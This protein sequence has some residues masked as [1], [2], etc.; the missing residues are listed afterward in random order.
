MQL[1][2]LFIASI[3]VRVDHGVSQLMKLGMVT[4]PN[5]SMMRVFGSLC[6]VHVPNKVDVVTGTGRAKANRRKLDYKAIRGIFLG[7]AEERHAY[8]ILDCSTGKLLVSIHVSFDELDSVASQELKR[9]ELRKLGEIYELTFDYYSRQASS[10]VD[11]LFNGDTTKTQLNQD[12]LDA[13]ESFVRQFNVNDINGDGESCLVDLEQ[14]HSLGSKLI[15]K[16]TDHDLLKVSKLQKCAEELVGAEV[17]Q[18]RATC[19]NSAIVASS[20]PIPRTFTEAM[21]SEQ[22]E[23]WRAAIE[24]EL[25]SIKSHGTWK[26]VEAP[27]DRKPLKTTWVFRVK[28]NS[29][30]TIDRYK[31]RLVVKGFL[32]VKGLDY[33]DVFAHVMRLESLRTLL[34]IAN[35]HDL[36]VDQMDIDTAFLYGVLEDTIYIEVP[37][38]IS[39]QEISNEVVWNGDPSKKCTARGVACLLVK[40]LYGL[41]QSPH[42]WHKVLTLF[43]SEIGF[44]KTNAESCIY[45]RQ[46][47]G[48]LSIVAIYV[49]DLVLV[50]EN[51]QVMHALKTSIKQRFSSKDLGPIHYILG[52]RITRNRGQ[53]TMH[54]S[55]Q[56]NALNMLKRFQLEK[57]RPA[58]TPM[59]EILTADDCPSVGETEGDAYAVMHASYRQGVGSLMYLM[60]GTRPDLAFAVQS[61]SRFLHRPGRKHFGQMKRVMR[62]VAGTMNYGLLYHGQQLNLSGYT[63]S[64]YA[65]NPDNRKSI[66]GYCTFVGKCLVSWSSQAQR[67]VAQSTTEAEYIALAQCAKEVLFMRTLNSELGNP[68]KAGSIIRADNQPA[69]ATACNPVNHSRTKHIDVRY[70]FVRERIQLEELKLEYV[71]SKE[72]LADL[73]TKPLGASLYLP[74]RDKLGLTPTTAPNGH[75]D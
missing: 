45:T 60:L 75:Q 57:A 3:V 32:Q 58:S 38:G 15:F 52:L 63:D 55:Q 11:L 47:K 26:Y 1:S 30:G 50:A 39:T 25:D 40:S 19:Y 4:P 34:A 68:V 46:Q 62:Y 17:E 64:D 54:I 51:D 41:K 31:A 48:Q 65:A 2:A 21:N 67:I 73:F 36:P 7:Y 35:A 29:D 66:S 22:G 59:D 23:E 28:E 12:E 53:R 74:L 20:V 16:A 13:L 10:D 27:I 33:N 61:L 70:H 6:Y 8:K 44:E 72:N 18:H 43:L 14:T 9:N 49:D 42:E 69:M 71:S 5:L 56:L 24:K 37:D